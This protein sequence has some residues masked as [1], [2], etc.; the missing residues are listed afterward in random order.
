M[1]VEPLLQRAREGDEDHRHDGGG[2]D[3]VREQNGE[4]DGA[5]RALPLKLRRAVVVV[6][7]Q[8]RDQKQRRSDERADH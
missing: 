4:V 1:P 3:R 7:S 5:D 6:I 2:Q 8:V